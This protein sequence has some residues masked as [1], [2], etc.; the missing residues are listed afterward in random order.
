MLKQQILEDRRIEE[1]ACLYRIC[2]HSCGPRLAIVGAACD[3]DRCILR[4]KAI[5]SLGYLR[6]E[7]AFFDSEAA[8]DICEYD[9]VIHVALPKTEPDRFNATYK[10]YWSI[11]GHVAHL[12]M[13]EGRGVPR[14]L[15]AQT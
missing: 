11:L 4:L 8:P 7:L 5:P 15:P 14:T 3:L 9:D 2:G 10:L 13:I 12:G 1:T 6:G